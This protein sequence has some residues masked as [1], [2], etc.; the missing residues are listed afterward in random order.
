MYVWPF[1]GAKCSLGLEREGFFPPLRISKRLVGRSNVDV[2][3]QEMDQRVFDLYIPKY[4]ELGA[5]S[6]DCF[7]V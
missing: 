2:A 4:L 5:E 6:T 1:L 3:L 7:V